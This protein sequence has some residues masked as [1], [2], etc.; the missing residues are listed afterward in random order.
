MAH[1]P[2][3]HL[4]GPDLRTGLHVGIQ[5]R[6]KPGDRP[7]RTSSPCRPRVAVNPGARRPRQPHTPGYIVRVVDSR[8]PTWHRRVDR[9]PFT[10]PT[11]FPYTGLGGSPGHLE[12]AAARRFELHTTFEDLP[13][14][15]PWSHH[16]RR[17][18]LVRRSPCFCTRQTIR[19]AY[20]SHVSAASSKLAANHQ[21]SPPLPMTRTPACQS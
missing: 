16:R 5:I 18:P 7:S 12:V 3:V 14:S 4:G 9:V 11:T 13:R 8:P 1:A 21:P 6:R 2:P 10:I 19:F 20:A 15:F 17:R